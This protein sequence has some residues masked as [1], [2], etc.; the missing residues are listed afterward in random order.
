M[1]LLVRERYVGKV[2][3]KHATNDRLFLNDSL[4]WTV[5]GAECEWYW[6]F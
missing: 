6:P 1:K 5:S 3:S 2:R 4:W